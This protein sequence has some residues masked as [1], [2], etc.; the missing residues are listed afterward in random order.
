M[1]SISLIAKWAV[2]HCS[3]RVGNADHVVKMKEGWWYFLFLAL[4][5]VCILTPHSTTTTGSARVSAL[6]VLCAYF[7]FFFPPRHL[8]LC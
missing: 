2:A 7:F 4:A 3:E 1:K 6:C 8:R 5:R